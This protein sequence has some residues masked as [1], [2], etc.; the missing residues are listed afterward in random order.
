MKGSKHIT[1]QVDTYEKLETI[2]TNIKRKMSNTQV[3][4][5]L[6]SRFIDQEGKCW[7]ELDRFM[8]QQKIRDI[9]LALS[10][11]GWFDFDIDLV[12]IT[13]RL[14]TGDLETVKLIVDSKI[15][16]KKETKR[17]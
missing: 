15:N 8:L 1:V 6:C 9:F 4:D 5:L 12:T 16:A 7:S 2:K 13:T 14:L 11:D 17:P 10:L 3:I